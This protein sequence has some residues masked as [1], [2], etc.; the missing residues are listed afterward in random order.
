MSS[1]SSNSSRGIVSFISLNSHQNQPV[2]RERYR[3]CC[4][5]CHIK[6]GTLFLGLLEFTV[7]AGVLYGI[8][9][10]LVWKSVTYT[11][12]ACDSHILRDCLL[13]DFSHFSLT[14][15][16]DYII[17]LLLVVVLFSIILMFC[18]IFSDTSCLL[19][20][21]LF[22]QAIFLLFSVGYFVLYA[23]SYFYGDLYTH[24]RSFEIQSCIERMWLASVLLI[25]ASFQVYLFFAVFK[26]S[27]YLAKIDYSRRQRETAFQRL[28]ERVRIAKENGLWR[29]SGVGGFMSYTRQEEDEKRKREKQ[30]VKQLGHVQW[31]NENKVVL[32]DEDPSRSEAPSR[33][34]VQF[35]QPV[36]QPQQKMSVYE[37]EPVIEDLPA[38]PRRRST[39]TIESRDNAGRNP[40][41]VES[42]QMTQTTAF[43]SRSYSQ[44]D[45]SNQAAFQVRR[46]DSA[47][48]YDNK[49]KG[50]WPVKIP[51]DETYIPA[52]PPAPVR[53]KSSREEILKE[54]SHAA[55]AYVNARRERVER[56][57][58]EAKEAR[59]SSSSS[60]EK[61]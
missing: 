22:V 47:Q 49:P 35:S 46:S 14:L 41:H 20:P 6:T 38:E 25:L 61:E 34:V 21:H 5:C 16:F 11:R 24:R 53:R 3:T 58:R 42:L 18:G 23:W 10:Q 57:L 26:C 4:D 15:I 32:L 36:Q 1:I 44:K 50:D 51:L 8:V 12:G 2:E 27:M 54:A 59:T 55:I 48:K 31:S 7:L 29:Q 33:Q 19:F 40:S 37:F 56:E 52:T 45:R 30:R 28:S 39:D 9:Q 43:N 13:L 60:P 17:A